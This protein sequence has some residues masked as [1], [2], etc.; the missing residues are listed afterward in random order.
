MYFITFSLSSLE[1]GTGGKISWE[2]DKMLAVSTAAKQNMSLP[3]QNNE[4]C[5][6]KSIKL[7]V[8]S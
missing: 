8:T 3:L 4:A 5:V 7:S 1:W 2:R 6:N